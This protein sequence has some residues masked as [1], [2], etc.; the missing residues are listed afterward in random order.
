[1]RYL[2]L[3]AVLLSGCGGYKAYRNGY[4]DAL[5]CIAEHG[6]KH[7]NKASAAYLYCDGST[8]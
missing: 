1:M 3:V 5:N 7:G 2:L 8:K 6:Y 4:E